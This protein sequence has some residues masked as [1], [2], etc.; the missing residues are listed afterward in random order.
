MRLVAK[1]KKVE[2]KRQE[3]YNTLQAQFERLK[4]KF[5]AQSTLLDNVMTANEE[6]T[7]QNEV[8]E[9]DLQALQKNQKPP[10]PL[11]ENM[12]TLTVSKGL[13]VVFEEASEYDSEHLR[14]DPSS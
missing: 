12:T 13:G 11:Q 3:K 4:M 9:S 5:A 6:L 14:R 2:I 10:L 7:S 1:M 8:M